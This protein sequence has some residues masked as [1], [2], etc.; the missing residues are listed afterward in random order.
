MWDDGRAPTARTDTLTTGVT[1]SFC[2]AQCRDRFAADPAR[3]LDR[4]DPVP[5][6]P[7]AVHTCPMHP[8]VEQV[9]PGDC[10][11]CGMGLEP[12]H[13]VPNTATRWTCPMHP[14]VVSDDPGDCPI[15]GMA[16]EPRTVA[17]SA[18]NPELRDMTRRFV[19][20]SAFALPVFAIAMG[21]MLPSRPFSTA[22]GASRPWVELVLATPVVLWAA[23]P[24]FVR[25]VASVRN[26]SPNMW[27][28]IG[29]GVSVAYGYSVL[30]TVAPD[31]FPDAFRGH[32]GGV[33]V[34]FEASAVIVA[35]ILLGQVLEL[36]ARSRTSAAIAKL[37]ELSA[38]SA[39]RV[40]ADGTEVD[41]PLEQ[42]GRR[43]PPPGASRGEDPRRWRG[44]RGSQ[45][46][47]RVDGHRRAHP[48]GQGGDRSG[49]RIDGQH[50]RVAADHR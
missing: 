33:A 35:L 42:V 43:G 22:L 49:D 29:L 38:G 30:A 46:G 19:V 11:S 39:R 12:K 44:D 14:E 17:V 16:L 27:T 6:D 34:Y 10:P 8:E 3:F 23:W 41:V 48:G 40:E 45:R 21:D 1:Y 5:S 50:H 26:R 9:G 28:L 20:A 4:S 2:S 31:L 32:G 18:D 36:R 24:F 15:C 13:A 7:S 25:G 37:L 47:G